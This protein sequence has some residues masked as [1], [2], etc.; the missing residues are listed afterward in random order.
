M[1][2]TKKEIHKLYMREWR[3]NCKLSS[4]NKKKGYDKSWKNNNRERINELNKIYR[5]R[6]KNKF[7]FKIERYTWKYQKDIIRKKDNY[8]CRYCY[9]PDCRLETHHFIYEYPPKIEDCT[10]VCNSCHTYLNKYNFVEVK[11]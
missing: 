6:E 1:G 10:T 4:K 8:Q 3:K 9:N 11:I 5:D 2:L 7:I